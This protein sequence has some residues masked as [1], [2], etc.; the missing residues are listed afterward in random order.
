MGSWPMSSI[1]PNVRALP[2]LDLSSK[3]KRYMSTMRGMTMM[4]IYCQWTQ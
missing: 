3:E 2:R 4:S 1:I